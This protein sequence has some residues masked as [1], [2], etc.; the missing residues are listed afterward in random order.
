M[1]YGSESRLDIE[2]AENLTISPGQS[3]TH[4]HTHTVHQVW[5]GLLDESRVGGVP[6]YLTAIKTSK[7][8]KGEGADEMLRE[9]TVM[10]Q[11]KP[12]PNLVSLIGVV[13][14]G[15]PM[16]LIL[17]LCENGSL[18]SV[19]QEKKATAPGKPF[20][21][22]ERLKMCLDI[23]KGMVA[24]I[25]SS[26]IHRD[27]AARNVLVDSLFVCKI[28]DFGLSRGIT[29]SEKKEEDR[30]EKDEEDY[31]RSRNGTFPVRWTAIESMQTMKFSEASDVWSFGVTLAE[32]YNDGEKPY[33][34]MTNMEVLKGVSSGYRMP[35]MEACESNVYQLILQCWREDPRKRP[36]CAELQSFFESLYVEELKKEPTKKQLGVG[37]FGKEKVSATKNGGGGN[38]VNITDLDVAVGGAA[39]PRGGLD[40][41]LHY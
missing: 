17:S 11:L 40:D 23:A 5:K 29:S 32:I 13:T 19:L 7:E 35:Q 21:K 37:E 34:N 2:S 26:L 31:Y 12:H 9:A 24:M 30:D 36:T 25:E 38:D 18:L 1:Y 27:L 8:A 6:G 28:A 4:T 33:S 14:S 20:K 3:L 39:P 10:A 16:L 15:V 41:R 22:F